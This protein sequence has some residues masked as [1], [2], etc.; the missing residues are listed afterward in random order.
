MGCFRKH[1][2]KNTA[3]LLRNKTAVLISVIAIGVESTGGRVV[4]VISWINLVRVEQ[5]FLFSNFEKC[6][7]SIENTFI[8]KLNY[9]KIQVKGISVKFLFEFFSGR[10]PHR[11]KF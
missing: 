2:S 7:N 11:K 1:P 6:S 3:S 8:F 4:W 9:S 10:N 5:L